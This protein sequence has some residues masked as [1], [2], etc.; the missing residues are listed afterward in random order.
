MEE[1][2]GVGREIVARGRVPGARDPEVPVPRDRVA[3]ERRLLRRRQDVPRRVEEDHGGVGGEIRGVDL[4]GVVRVVDPEAVRGAERLDEGRPR[5]DLR[6]VIESRG[7]VEDEDLEGLAGL[8]RRGRGRGQ[9]EPS[10]GEE[11]RSRAAHERL[12]YTPS[13]EAAPEEEEES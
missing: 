7:L 3:L 13:R 5:Q 6:R 12:P 2:G 10:E 4:R 8:R 9:E 11:T 1:W